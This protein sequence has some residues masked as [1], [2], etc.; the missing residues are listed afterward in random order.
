MVGALLIPWAITSRKSTYH[1]L[2]GQP[3]SL[4][5]LFVR[6]THSIVS[7][8]GDDGPLVIEDAPA[9]NASLPDC[10]AASHPIPLPEHIRHKVRIRTKLSDR[11]IPTLP[12]KIIG[13]CGRFA[14]KL[15]QNKF[16]AVPP[17]RRPD[18]PVIRG[19]RFFVV[20]YRTAEFR[21]VKDR[22]T[23]AQIFKYR[24]QLGPGMLKF[25]LIAHA[26]L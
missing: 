8:S 24:Q 4:L 11:M 3:Q 18:F 9:I 25:A 21:R 10:C 14:L 23:S 22:L 16:A 6:R 15:A 20:I 2:P 7:V 26:R 19:H 17:S 12:A 5:I 1:Y 13:V